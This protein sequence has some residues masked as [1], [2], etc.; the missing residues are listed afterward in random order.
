MV[1]VEELISLLEHYNPKAEVKLL[2]SE[3]IE[4]S[5]ICKSADGEYY[6]NAD[7]PIVFI[8]GRDYECSNEYMN[9]DIRWCSHFDK[10]C[11]G[12]MDCEN[13]E[14]FNE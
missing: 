4:L 13:Y 9:G 7:T 3:S 14:G 2:D 1:L 11:K 8:E 6:T 10:P 12:S 5:Y